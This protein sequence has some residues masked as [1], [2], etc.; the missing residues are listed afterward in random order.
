YSVDWGLG[1]GGRG[2]QVV[3]AGTMDQLA[4]NKESL[5]G[6]YLA[7]KRQIAIP[8]QRRSING[9]KLTIRG[10]RH[11]NLKNIDV[12][13]PLGLFVCV[14]GVSGSGESSPVH[15]ILLGVVDGR[16]GGHE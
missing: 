2:G 15:D 3:A 11:N 13:I 5:T 10:A 14:T 7:G 4:A 6:Q 12:E 16:G 1:P 8:P 9:R